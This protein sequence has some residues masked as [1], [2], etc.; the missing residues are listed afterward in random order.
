MQK[1]EQHIIKGQVQ[2]VGFRPFVFKL[3]MQHALTGFVQNTPQGVLIEIQGDTQ[4]ICQFNG[5]FEKKLPPL[6]RISDHAKQE[7]PLKKDE[8]QFE[9]ILSKQGSHEGHSVLVSPDVAICADC[10]KDMFTKTNRRYAYAFTNCTACGPRYTITKSIPYDRPVTTMGC[11]PLCEH[12]HAEYTNPLDRRFHAQPNAC[13]DCG[14]HIWLTDGTDNAGSETENPPYLPK[15]QTILAENNAAVLQTIQYLNQGKIVAVKGL[16]G[17]QLA[18]SAFDE[19][20]VSVLRQRKNRPDKAFAIMVKDL[21]AAKEL[22]HINENA[23]K[24]LTSPSA[25]IVLCPAKKTDLPKGIA[26]DTHRIGIM[27][28]YTPLHLLLFSPELLTEQTTLQTPIEA[29]RALIMT[30]AN[31]GGK[32]I[33]IQNRQALQDLKNIA[34]YYLFHDRDILIRVDDSVCLSLEQENKTPGTV[35]NS[36]PKTIFFRRARG[37]VPTPVRFPDNAN[38]LSSVFATGTFLKN[39]FTFT[40]ENEAYQSQHIGDLDNLEVLDFFEDTAKHLQKLLEVKPV[41][42]ATDLHPDFPSTHIAEE[43]SQNN[44]LPLEKIQHHISHAYAVLAEQKELC[45]SPYFA[46]ILDGTGL[47]YDNTIW[48]GEIFYLFAKEKRHYRLASL[49]SIALI[50]G[51]KATFEPWRIAFACHKKAQEKGYL[52]KDD[53]FPF[54]HKNE[55]AEPLQQCELMLEKNINCPKSSGCGRLFD[56]VSALLEICTQTSYEGQAAI[57]LETEAFPSSNAACIEIPFGTFEEVK[58]QIMQEIKENK[59]ASSYAP[60][61]EIDSIYLYAK[62]FKLLQAG[63]AVPDIAKIFHNSLAHALSQCLIMLKKEFSPAAQNELPKLILGGGVFNNELLLHALC[64]ELSPE[65]TLLFPEQSPVGDASVSLGQ[66]F[67]SSLQ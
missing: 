39:T 44:A 66:A 30:S 20:A 48:G 36:L 8:K 24:L 12:C 28:A 16:G 13:A 27:L 40:K 57:K 19:K 67:Y 37:Y 7:I 59:P 25:P 62:L 15:N 64:K 2:G 10:K 47:G 65:F 5:D 1:R 3:A 18:C 50:G 52:T 6:A 4:N 22:A 14:P 54:Y 61:I 23:E 34:D 60:Y 51:D 29:P 55:Y 46:M 56:A 63:T 31:Q 42:T 17:F 38:Y 11:F 45:S 32:P 21:A 35:Q 49:S 26:P 41:K 53:I 58:A 33:C 43:Y 9:I